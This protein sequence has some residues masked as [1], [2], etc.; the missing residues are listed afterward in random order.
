MSRKIIY[1]MPSCSDNSP[2]ILKKNVQR[3]SALKNNGIDISG[4]FFTKDDLSVKSITPEI[5]KIGY[6]DRFPFRKFPFLWRF[7]PKY[8][9]WKHIRIISSQVNKI[10]EDPKNTFIYLRYPGASFFAL[11]MLKKWKQ[12]GINFCLEMNGKEDIMFQRQVEK[13]PNDLFAKYSLNCEQRYASKMMNCASLV[14]GV[15]NEIANY[16][17]NNEPSYTLSNG[18]EIS[19]VDSHIRKLDE[20]ELIKFVLVTGS[21]HYWIGVD[22]IINSFK[23]YTGNAN[24]Q[25]HLVGNI[26]IN[27]LKD[28]PNN[29]VHHGSKDKS[30]LDQIIPDMHVGIGNFGFHR[31]N[32]KETNALKVREYLARGLP[33]VIGYND[34]DLSYDESLDFVY[35]AP[36]DESEIDIDALVN[37]VKKLYA[38]NP[39]INNHVRVFA[40]KKFDYNKKM[41]TFLTYLKEKNLI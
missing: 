28:L 36:A 40:E 12:K 39:L 11:R 35:H 16:Y 37:W 32:I 23:N 7:I 14:I 5:V 38:T 19:S 29:I 17:K 20:Q 41:K 9:H 21:S 13:N 8:A 30:E 6:S 34:T 33:V 10:I 27:L 4:L 26:S 2:G 25:L 18:Y 24:I 31:M 1:I 22:R 3:V 15:S